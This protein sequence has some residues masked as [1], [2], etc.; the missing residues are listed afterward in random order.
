MK[1]RINQS[2]VS[3]NLKGIF[4]VDQDLLKEISWFE[5]NFNALSHKDFFAKRPSEYTKALVS[6]SKRS[7]AVTKEEVLK[8][9]K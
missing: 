2:L 9:A 8:L 6:W 1:A 5:D 4:K 3:M 7:V